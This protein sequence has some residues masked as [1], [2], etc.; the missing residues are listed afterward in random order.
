MNKGESGVDSSCFG[1][2][3][4]G[5]TKLGGT[6]VENFRELVVVVFCGASSGDCVVRTGG[7]VRGYGGRGAVLVVRHASATVTTSLDDIVF[8]VTA[9]AASGI[10]AVDFVMAFATNVVVLVSNSIVLRGSATVVNFLVRGFLVGG[11]TIF[12]EKVRFW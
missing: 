9:S 10:F 2:V 4:E 3:I 5:I 12:G 7:I 1:N 6:D 11:T 8:P